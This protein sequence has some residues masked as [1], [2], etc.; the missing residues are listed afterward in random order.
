[1]PAPPP[2]PADPRAPPA[3]HVGAAPNQ[4]GSVASGSG[5]R[6]RDDRHRD[7][8]RPAERTD[9]ERAQDAKTDQIVQASLSRR[10]SAR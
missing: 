7:G 9:D 8:S 1:M 10:R 2:S 4:G 3:V 6:V 5:E